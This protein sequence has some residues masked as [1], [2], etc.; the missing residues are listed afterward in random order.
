MVRAMKT[1]GLLSLVLLAAVGGCENAHS[2]L[3]SSKSVGG[4]VNSEALARVEE[5]LKGIEDS[6]KIVPGGAADASA[7]ERLQRV[8]IALA[9]Y[10]EALEF[11]QSVYAQQKQQ[12]EQKEA[13][14]ADPNAVFAVDVS[15]AVKAGQTEGPAAGAAVTII[16]AFD[17]A[18]PYCEKLT[19]P[20][21][22]LV[23]EYNGQVRV[24]YMN[25]VVHPDSAMTGHLYSCAAAKQGK[26]VAFKDAFWEKSFKPYVNSRGKDTQ[27]M[28]EENILKYAGAMGLNTQQLK[29]DANGAECKARIAADETELRKYRVSATPGLF[30]NG[31][32]IGGAIPKEAF[33]QIIDEKLK[34]VAAS[35]IPPA[36]YYDKEIMTNGLKV[37]R[38]KRDAKNDAKKAQQQPGAGSGSA[39]KATP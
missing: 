34:L 37:F 33:K 26:Y 23:K 16:K 35:K 7:S 5:R 13:G 9:R 14:E 2:K 1:L 19:E 39:E 8:E 12:A 28:G 22:E 31:T 36:Q 24:V 17:F 25:L 18:C 21:H 4:G 10:G 30:I 6:L 38:S 29:T 11:L 3:D 20:L 32:F 15:G 27:A